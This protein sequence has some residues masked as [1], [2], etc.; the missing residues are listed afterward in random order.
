MP[1]NLL[2][3][4]IFSNAMQVEKELSEEG[5]VHGDLDTVNHLIDQHHRF[6]KDLE[7]RNAQMETVMRTGHELEA[8]AS[9]HDAATIRTELTE[10][11][12]LWET[13]SE[14]THRK[15]QRLVD[16]LHEAEKLHKSVHMLLDW[17]SD[18]EMKLRFAGKKL[19]L[20]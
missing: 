9:K 7:A 5:P 10:L 20:S 18:A 4:C 16:A 3:S 14:L 13:V 12:N 1:H 15:S 19:S 6:E 17:L 8:K 11:N 2:I